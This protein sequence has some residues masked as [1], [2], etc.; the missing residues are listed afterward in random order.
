MEQTSDTDR[1]KKLKL[2]HWEF[3]TNKINMLKAVMG[4]A[5]SVQE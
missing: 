1:A 3:K 5:D 4:K 2:L